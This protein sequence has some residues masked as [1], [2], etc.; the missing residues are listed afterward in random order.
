[1]STSRGISK[2]IALATPADMVADLVAD[3]QD[4][5]DTVVAL[6]QADVHDQP[7]MVVIQTPKAPA[8]LPALPALP[9]SPSPTYP[10]T[11]C[12]PCT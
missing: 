6:P 12:L 2:L 7:H 8:S 3:R 9:P 1:M 5:A 4:R 10:R 11:A